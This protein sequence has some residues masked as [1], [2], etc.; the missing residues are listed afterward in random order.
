M[1]IEIELTEEQE[2]ELKEV[3]GA[4]IGQEY[5]VIPAQIKIKNW[6]NSMTKSK[7]VGR[8]YTGENATEITRLI[9]GFVRR[10]KEKAPD[11]MQKDIEI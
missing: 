3:Q 6:D 9:N 10:L 7:V 1:K 8:L 2:K 11:S 4:I 5:F